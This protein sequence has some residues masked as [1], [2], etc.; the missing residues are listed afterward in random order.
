MIGPFLRRPAM[1]ALFAVGA[2]GSCAPEQPQAPQPDLDEVR[3]TVL[4]LENEMNLA[5]DALNCGLPEN[6]DREP[7]FVSGGRVVRTGSE[8][9]EMCQNMV[10]N[11]TG[12]VFVADR[13]TANVLSTDVA[14]VVR[15]GNYT[16]NYTDGTSRT[17]YLVMT[18]IW[19]REGDGWK[20][21][22]LHESSR[23]P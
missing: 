15:E 18:T 14:Y 4:R 8:L 7:I 22:H 17:P 2:T 10:A 6:G 9:Q 16:I 1:L 19:H 13:I 20:M 21:V 12:A 5:V 23:Q 3:E 11:R